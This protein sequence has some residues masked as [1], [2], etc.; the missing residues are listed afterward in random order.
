MAVN[1]RELV[2]H[3]ALR[4]F[5]EYGFH[6]TGIDKVQA[7]S[8]VSKTTMYKYFK[9]KDA[10]IREVLELRHRQFDAWMRQRISELSQERYATKPEGHLLAMFD[11]LDEW[12]QLATFCGCN[13]INASTEYS[14][15]MHPVHRLAAEHKLS[16]TDYIRSLLP[17]DLQVDRNDLA[18]EICL[19]VDGA[20]V[21]AHT[22]GLKD[23]AQRAKR[24]A[25]LLIAAAHSPALELERI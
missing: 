6:A 22:T 21:C 18:K 14:D 5:N 20:I 17:E 10:L 19:L 7:E 4:L 13:F 8:G 16:L 15:L 1:K 23:S 24:M 9:S 3:T 11:T 2:L 25:T 12:F